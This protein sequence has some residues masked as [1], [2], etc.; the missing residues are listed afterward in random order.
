VTQQKIPDLPKGWTS[1]LLGEIAETASGGTPS[2]HRKEFF[3]GSIPWVKSGELNDATL[4]TTQEFLSELG[5]QSSSAKIFP[6]GTLCIALY[7]ATVGKL[8]I[9]RRDA[10]TNQA[11]CGIFVPPLIDTHYLFYFLLSQRRNLIDLGKGGAQPN[12]SQ[13]IIRRIVIPIPPLAE[14]GRIASKIDELVTKLFVGIAELRK[15]QVQLKRYRQAV[16]KA[17]VTGELT[18]DWRASRE[19]P[20]SASP[21]IVRSRDDRR[22][23]LKS[24]EL[25]RMQAN[26]MPLNNLERDYI[27]PP[28]EVA[29]KLWKLPEGWAWVTVGQIGEVTGGLTKNPRREKLSYKIPYLRVANVYAGQLDLMEVK[30]IGIEENEIERVLL[31][32]GD[33]LVVEGNG[34]IDQIGRV[35]LWD[36]KIALCAHQNHLIKVRFAE[37]KLGEYV[38]W[39]FLSNEGRNFITRVASSTSGLH[40]LN[41]SKVASLPV[42]LPPL[43]EQQ[44]I[45]SEIDRVFSITNASQQ[46]IGLTSRQAERLRQSILKQA[47][48]GKL[49]KQHSNDEPAELLLERI[50]IER[51]KREMEA[52]SKPNR[53]RIPKNRSKRTERPAA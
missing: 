53:K 49:I 43:M 4:H 32:P 25:A 51:A 24:G 38:L 46:A 16:L 5:L 15:A 28:A 23:V 13:E 11:V 8:G 39:W 37:A 10:A 34:S 44:Q 52:V 21:L 6:A 40:T 9:L 2:R 7:G 14:Q 17:A 22:S 18:R 12:I 41:I 1:A 48:E 29:D 20:D 26:A 30:T 50:R 19:K 45:V 47:F 33:L 35:A 42:P 3:V 27:E 36:G 31:A